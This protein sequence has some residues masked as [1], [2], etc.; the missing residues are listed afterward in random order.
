MITG[1][2]IVSR[3]VH[4]PVQDREKPI[5]AIQQTVLSRFAIFLRFWRMFV[6]KG[7]TSA[8]DKNRFYLLNFSGLGG[9]APT[10]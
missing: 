6:W 10:R 4:S 2:D 9:E 5:G 1:S 3:V 7:Q 8:F